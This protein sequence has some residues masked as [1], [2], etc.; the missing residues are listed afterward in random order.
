MD[1]ASSSSSLFVP[2]HQWCHQVVSPPRPYLLAAIKLAE[3]RSGPPGPGSGHMHRRCPQPPGVAQFRFVKRSRHVA[4][5]SGEGVEEDAAEYA[6]R[7]SQAGRIRASPR[8][9]AKFNT[10]LSPLQKSDLCSTLFGGI[11]NLAKTL[12]ADLT[13]YLV[14]CYNQENSEM[15][16]VGRE[17]VSVDADSMHKLLDLPNKCQKVTYVVDKDATRRFGKT[18]NINENYHPQI[19][20]WCKM[21]QYMMGKLVDEFF[22][23][24]LAILYLDALLHDVPLSNCRHRADTNFGG[25]LQVEAFLASK[26]PLAYD[27]QLVCDL[28]KSVTEQ[29]GHFIEAVVKIDEEETNIDPYVWKTSLETGRS[30][31]VPQMKRRVASRQ[32]EKE[33]AKQ[34]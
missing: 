28:C 22:N 34:E 11:L 15:V 17:R 25:L 16:F 21:I 6:D 23:T 5:G 14:K 31:S 29:V 24:W 1:L 13:K 27:L 30:H 33:F 26:L 9:F 20:T 8:R 18:F 12:P 32:E 7:P 3:P 4:I 2:N 10:K 19:T